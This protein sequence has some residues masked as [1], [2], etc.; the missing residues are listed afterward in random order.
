[1]GYS[2]SDEE[3][4]RNCQRG[5]EQGTDKVGSQLRNCDQPK[6]LAPGQSALD[7]QGRQ[8]HR[9][10]QRDNGPLGATMTV[11]TTHA[12]VISQ[13][14]SVLHTTGGGGRPWASSHADFPTTTVRIALPH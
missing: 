14:A 5:I 13:R 7:P 6:I 10:R 9:H 2:P 3:A 8:Y 12:G 1:M 4:R 11:V